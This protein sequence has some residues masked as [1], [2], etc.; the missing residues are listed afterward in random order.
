MGNYVVMPYGLAIGFE[1]MNLLPDFSWGIAV[2]EEE[3]VPLRRA[4]FIHP[5]TSEQ[6]TAIDAIVQQNPTVEV[7]NAWPS[8]WRFP[9][10]PTNA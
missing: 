1:K 5:W 10:D 4:M 8:D 9:V 7:V 6:A 2:H 3:A